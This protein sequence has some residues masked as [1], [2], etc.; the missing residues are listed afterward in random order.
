MH[1]AARMRRRR[2]PRTPA[3]RPASGAIDRQRQRRARAGAPSTYSMTMYGWPSASPQSCTATM[4]GMAEPRQ[5]L[6]LAREALRGTPAPR[7]ARR[8][9]TSPPPGGRGRGGERGTRRPCRRGRSPP[10]VSIAPPTTSRRQARPRTGSAR[11]PR[12]PPAAR[13]SARTRCRPR[14]PLS[15]CMQGADLVV[16]RRR[17]IDRLRHL[18]AQQLAVAH[19]GP[20]QE[21][22]ELRGAHAV[23]RR[24][25]LVRRR[26]RCAAEERGDERERAAPLPGARTR[27]AGAPGRAP[28]PRAPTRARR[29]AREQRGAVEAA[30]GDVEVERDDR[31]PRRRASA[32]RRARVFVARWWASPCAGTNGSGRAPDRVGRG[33]AL[34]QAGDEALD[35]ILGGFDVE[36]LAAREAVERLSSTAPAAPPAPPAAPRIAARRRDQGPAGGGNCP[37]P[38]MAG[39]A[40]MGG[41][42]QAESP[43]R[44]RSWSATW[45]FPALEGRRSVGAC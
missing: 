40:R 38:G 14:H 44:P 12:M 18:V 42:Y 22:L 36:P 21:G 4:C 25:L 6:R 1:H 35:G 23:R 43:P 27:R 15:A 19:A 7:P 28:S 20:V 31:P 33:V 11:T 9:G 17:I 24:R 26:C 45:T 3:R 39:R 41:V 34:E 5:G 37:D 30:L 16:D 8:G 2:A 10:R 29:P 13:R 32:P